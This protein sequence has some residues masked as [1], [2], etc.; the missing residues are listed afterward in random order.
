MACNEKTQGKRPK[1]SPWD[2]HGRPAVWTGIVAQPCLRSQGSGML[3]FGHRRD[4]DDACIKHERF[5]SFQST[6]GLIR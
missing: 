3:A 1:L 4:L 5:S 6:R 2:I